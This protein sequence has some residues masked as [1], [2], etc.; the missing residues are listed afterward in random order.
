MFVLFLA[1]FIL[2]ALSVK[3]FAEVDVKSAG[4]KITTAVAV[5]FTGPTVTKSGS[6]AIVDVSNITTALSV[7][8]PLNADSALTVDGTIYAANLYS[9]GNKRVVCVNASGFLYASA[10]TVD[11]N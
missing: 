11:C 2:I 7:A 5:D 4:T 1:S 8:G 3:S 10:T 9:G 6:K